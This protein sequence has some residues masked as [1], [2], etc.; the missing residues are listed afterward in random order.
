[1]K[2]LR[3]LFFVTAVLTVTVCWAGVLE[4]V[5]TIQV[6]PTVV[7]NPDAIKDPAAPNLVRFTL[8]AA[9]REAHFAE[10]NSPIRAH[11]V[12]NEFSNAGKAKRILNFDTGRT[13]NVVDGKLVFQDASGKEL[14]SRVIHFRGNVAFSSADAPRR[15]AVS[16][17]EQVLIDEIRGL[18]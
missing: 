15:Q 11:I 13:D 7:T 8:R 6:D 18:K 3:A 14:A 17:F 12:L 9:V 16:D 2:I 5:S 4:N 10:G 1:M